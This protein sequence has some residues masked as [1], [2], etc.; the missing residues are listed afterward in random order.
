MFH[1]GNLTESEAQR[2]ASNLTVFA[3]V[4]AVTVLPDEGSVLLK[5]AQTGW[6]EDGVRH[7][8][9]GGR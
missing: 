1:V 7:L 4:E 6:D 9:Q 5:V 3:G 2:L 8:L